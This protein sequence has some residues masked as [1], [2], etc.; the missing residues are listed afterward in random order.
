[1]T[2]EKLT[3]GSNDFCKI[4]QTNISMKT[5]ADLIKE[6]KNLND[7]FAIFTDQYN[8]KLAVIDSQLEVF[9]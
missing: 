2:Y 6:K 4:V 3:E 1:M 8:E 7:Q 9:K 5:E